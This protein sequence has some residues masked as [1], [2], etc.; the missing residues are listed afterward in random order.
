MN[1]INLYTGLG[2]RKIQKVKAFLKVRNG[3]IT[4]NN[5]I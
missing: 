5:S 1:E 3:N 4:V 2:K